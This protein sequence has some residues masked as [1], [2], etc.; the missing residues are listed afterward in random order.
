MDACT[1]IKIGTVIFTIVAIAGTILLV[2]GRTKPAA[3]L[4]ALNWAL[5]AFPLAELY[6]EQHRNATCETALNVAALASA[7]FL[8]THS[9]L[10]AVALA[11]SE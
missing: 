11:S 2:R 8:F 5:I 10:I 9:L 7:F 3:A 4:I 6:R 1:L